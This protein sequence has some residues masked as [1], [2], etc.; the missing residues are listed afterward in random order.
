M[1]PLYVTIQHKWKTIQIGCHDSVKGDNDCLKEV[2]ITVIMGKFWDFYNQILNI[3]PL[4]TGLTVIG[5][6][7]NPHTVLKTNPQD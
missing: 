2:K 5:I 6:L 1:V 7:K 4:F 3:M